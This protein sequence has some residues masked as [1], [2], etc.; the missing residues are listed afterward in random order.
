MTSIVPISTIIKI[1]SQIERA[2]INLHEVKINS[3]DVKIKNKVDELINNLENFTDSEILK[4]ANN[5]HTKYF[6]MMCDVH[7]FIWNENC[8]NFNKSNDTCTLL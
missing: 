8:K 3:N 5:M 2:K 7:H 4:D 6:D 1:A